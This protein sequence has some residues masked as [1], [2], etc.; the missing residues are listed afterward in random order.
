MIFQGLKS[1]F[2]CQNF[3]KK[4]LQRQ[5]LNRV[6]NI[7][8]IRTVLYLTFSLIRSIQGVCFFS[9]FY[10]WDKRV[11][12]S[13]QTLDMALY[14]WVLGLIVTCECYFCNVL[15]SCSESVVENRSWFLLLN[16]ASGGFPRTNTMYPLLFS[17]LFLFTLYYKDTFQTVLKS[18]LKL[19]KKSEDTIHSPPLC[20]CA[21]KF[22]KKVQVPK[23]I[24]KVLNEFKDVMPS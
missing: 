9:L 12:K 19:S 24:Q 20:P 17:Q 6:F 7:S 2:L 13:C 23:A 3:Q 5:V 18:V 14:N 8:I 15:G 10:K 21:I 16:W 22:I 11:S 1:A 4:N